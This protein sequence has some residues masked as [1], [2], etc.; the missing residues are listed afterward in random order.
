MKF[1]ENTFL[2]KVVQM[3]NKKIAVII[4]FKLF[5]IRWNL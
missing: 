3:Y 4:S 5:L 1:K 2:K